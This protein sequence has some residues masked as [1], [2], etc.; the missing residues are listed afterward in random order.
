MDDFKSPSSRYRPVAFWS[1]NDKLEAA[2]LVRQIRE[3]D[4]QG[5]GG[6]FM[7]ARAGLE[8]PYLSEE[9]FD[10]VETCVNE[11][12]SRGMQ[13]WIYDEDTWPSGWA[14][15]LIP[16]LG[17]EYREKHLFL[18]ENEI[19][20]HP[21]DI[22][23][24]KIYK[25]N[26]RYA[27]EAAY[28][29]DRSSAY[30]LENIAEITQEE[31]I[32]E[33][34]DEVILYFYQWTAPLTN[35]RYRGASYVDLLNPKVAEAFIA[36]THERYKEAIGAEF[37]ATVPGSFTDDLTVLWNIWGERS[38]R[39]RGRRRFRSGLLPDTATTCW[40]ACPNCIFRWKAAN[41]CESIFTIW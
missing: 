17:E 10:C 29:R 41:G 39:C 5:W 14:G 12:K 23:M 37:G 33:H 3:M 1:W 36:S 2:E 30:R 38:R 21:D 26:R 22:R 20:H 32:R 6:F 35:P 15:G 7:H 8:T 16:R 25:A 18:A 27:A 34:G 40:T 28:Y 19:P 9:W 13:A 24:L 31:A 11:A 4:E